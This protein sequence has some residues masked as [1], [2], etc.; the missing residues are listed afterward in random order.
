[1]GAIPAKMNGASWT[2]NGMDAIPAKMNGVASSSPQQLKGTHWYWC[3]DAL[4][5]RSL[6]PNLGQNYLQG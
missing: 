3:I 1:M 5:H 4:M 2:T 6:D